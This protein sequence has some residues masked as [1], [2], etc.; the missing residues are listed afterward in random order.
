MT[1]KI[2]SILGF[3]F[4]LV[5][6]IFVKYYDNNMDSKINN[7]QKYTTKD[8]ILKEF[9]KPYQIS[10]CLKNLWWNNNFLGI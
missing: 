9:G 8:Y 10:E 6:V 1:L 3:V 5:L 2:V 4:L 7:L